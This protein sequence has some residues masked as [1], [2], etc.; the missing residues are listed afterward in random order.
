MAHWVYNCG[1]DERKSEIGQYVWRD[2]KIE[3]VGGPKV[4]G[5][6]E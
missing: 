5:P 6:K 3:K 2:G 4:L 1:M